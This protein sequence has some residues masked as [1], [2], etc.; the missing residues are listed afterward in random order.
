VSKTADT[1]LKNGLY[2][3]NGKHH[4]V[5]GKFKNYTRLGFASSTLEELEM[6]LE[7]L[8]KSLVFRN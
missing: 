6:S 3:S 8:K 4:E 2:F 5:D 1:A 7:V